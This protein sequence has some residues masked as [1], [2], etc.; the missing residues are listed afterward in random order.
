MYLTRQQYRRIKNPRRKNIRKEISVF[1]SDKELEYAGRIPS[2]LDLRGKVEQLI[3]SVFIPSQR[4]KIEYLAD[5]FSD[6][7]SIQRIERTPGGLI[8]NLRCVL[9]ILI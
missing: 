7:E 5:G 3:S 1:F 8:C 4:V 6:N 2:Y 9:S